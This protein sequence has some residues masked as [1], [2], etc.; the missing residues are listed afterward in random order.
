MNDNEREMHCSFCGKSSTEARHF[1]MQ[2]DVC[3]C[4]A[5]VAACAQIMAEQDAEE[6]RIS[7]AHYN[8]CLSK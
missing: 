3:I 5:C 7:E 8:V 4:D 6:G 1:V 2:G